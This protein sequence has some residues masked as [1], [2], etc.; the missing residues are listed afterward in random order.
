VERERWGREMIA[1]IERTFPTVRDEGLCE[2][3]ERLSRARLYV[4]NDSGITHLAA[5]VGCSTVAIFG[6]SDAVQWRPIGA[7]VKVV[8]AERGLATLAVEEVWSGVRE[9]M[10]NE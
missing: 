3:A 8:Q 10:N 4:G 7:R 1:Q 9:Q 2:L 6:A 5:A